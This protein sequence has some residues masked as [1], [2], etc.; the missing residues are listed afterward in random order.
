MYKIASLIRLA[1]GFAAVIAMQMPL[2][3]SAALKP[4]LMFCGSSWRVGANLYAATGPFTEVTGCAP[5]AT[6]QALLITRSGTIAGNGAAWLAYLNA[7][8]NIITEWNVAAAVYNEIYGTAYTNGAGFGQCAD[9]AM[10]QVKLN[11]TD[12]FWVANPIPVTPSGQ[13]GCGY[14]LNT[15]VAGQ[16]S[17]TALGADL[18]GAISFARRAQGAG[19]LY[20]LEADWQDPP[21]AS[22]TSDSKTFMGALISSSGTATSV[23]IPT[24]SQWGMIIL[25][26][27]MVLGA[28]I[29]IRRQR[30]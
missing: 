11:P 23:P 9:N 5:T 3:A 15:L 30:G 27:L 2:P 13:G 8:G 28:L 19:L 6:T 21:P 18:S 22:F 26:G 17:V 24:L 16:P 7:G 20:L 4:N 14:S 25:S 1:A 29:V 12:P 10:P